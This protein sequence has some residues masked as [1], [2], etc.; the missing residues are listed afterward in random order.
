[1]NQHQIYAICHFVSQ[2][3][4]CE[5]IGQLRCTCVIFKSI[6]LL[7]SRPDRRELGIILSDLSQ[8]TNL[9]LVNIKM[10]AT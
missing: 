9:Y 2:F 4:F 3:L 10:N 8:W 1:M 6:I 5:E 7:H